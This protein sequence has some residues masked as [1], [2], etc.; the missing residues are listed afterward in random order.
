[1]NEELKKIIKTADKNYINKKF[2]E[3]IRFYELAIE[4]TKDT[5]LGFWS[6]YSI[7]NCGLAYNKVGN[8]SSA[9]KKFEMLPKEDIEFVGIDL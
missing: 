8:S 9:K 6:R 2:T 4:K 5:P 1:M 3:A 7:L